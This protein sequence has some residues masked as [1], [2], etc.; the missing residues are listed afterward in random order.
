M[1]KYLL[2]VALLLPTRILF[3]QDGRQKEPY[4]TRTLS[5]DNIR[6]V[7]ARTSGG[8][9]T[10]TG[11]APSEARI[12]VYIF[13]NNNSKLTKEEIKERLDELYNLD[14]SVANNKLSAMARG[15]GQ[16]RNWKKALNISYKIYV[17]QNVSTD[18]GTSGGSIQLDNLSG[19]QRFSTSGGSLHVSKTS[20]NIEGRTSGGSIHLEDSQ[21]EIDLRTSGGAIYAT[22]CN[23]QIRLATSGG[24][25]ELSNLKGTIKATT[26]GGNVKGREVGGELI[27][28]TSGGN[29]QLM[30]LSGSLETSTSGGN[31]DVSFRQMG[32]YV[33]VHNSS[34]NIDLVLP[35]N[36]GLDLELSGRISTTSIANFE[37]RIDDK[38]VLGKLN[39]GGVPVRVDANVGRIRLDW[40]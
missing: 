16:M 2:L 7:E 11:V 26:S 14:V 6:E 35:K 24:S 13:S 34:G 28:S 21:D 32:Q 9:I 17:P 40:Q 19:K 27:A 33:K 20:G 31:I 1:Y 30:N 23:G 36:A 8:S 5:A 4:L 12:E 10:V 3:A 22:N 37:G 25:L 39:G 18:L 15:K 29:V 38:Q